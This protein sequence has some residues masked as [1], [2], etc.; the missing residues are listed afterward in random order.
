VGEIAALRV[1]AGYA[2]WSAQQLESEIADGAWFVI[3]VA[4]EDCFSPQPAHLWHEV[5][6][7]QGG[8]FTTV[9]DN[10]VLN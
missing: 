9:T 4:P 2:G 10:P 6:R 8:M 1:F 7:R 3:D 5:L